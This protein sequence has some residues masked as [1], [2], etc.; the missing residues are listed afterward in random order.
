[1]RIMGNSANVRDMD[2]PKRL[3]ANSA[4]KTKPYPVS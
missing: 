1:M 2:S 3:K 4:N